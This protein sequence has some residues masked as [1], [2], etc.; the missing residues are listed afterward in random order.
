MKLRTIKM[1]DLSVWCGIA[2]CKSSLLETRVALLQFQ[3]LFPLTNIIKWICPDS[4]DSSEYPS[5]LNHR[6]PIISWQQSLALIP[7]AKSSAISRHSRP[8]CRQLKT[9]CIRNTGNRRAQ[10]GEYP[11]E[12]YLD[13]ITCSIKTVASHALIPIHFTCQ[14][15]KYSLFLPPRNPRPW[16]LLCLFAGVVIVA[17]AR[18]VERLPRPPRQQ[19]A[20][21]SSTLGVLCAKCISLTER[22]ATLAWSSSSQR[23]LRRARRREI[24]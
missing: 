3:F 17:A 7:L 12:Q 11:R 23:P 9:G 19:Q 21:L 4:F 10:R 24:G 6:T 16:A 13:F 5:Q 15:R 1:Y 8:T 2:T 20:I 22:L 14:S 18:E